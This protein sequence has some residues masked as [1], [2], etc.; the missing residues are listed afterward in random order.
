M[1]SG[2][3]GYSDEEAA[4]LYDVLSPWDA[5]RFASDAFYDD[6][7][8][9]A[10]SVLD[11]GCGTGSMMAQ[12]RQRGHRGRLTGLD[13]DR[14][15]LDR[16]RA[17]CP[18]AEWVQGVAARASWVGEFDL[19]TM[20]SHAF[21]FLVTD[22]ELGASL[23]AIK[24]ALRD[25]GLFAFET[26]HPQA[27]AWLDW[28]PSQVTDV[29]DA[30]GR[31]LRTWHEVESVDGDVVTFTETTAAAGTGTVLRV[32]RARLRFL[33]VPDLN[34]FL[35]EA[36]FVIEAQY[37]DWDRSPVTKDSREIITLARR[38]LAG[39]Q[40]AAE[41][42][43]PVAGVPGLAGHVVR[44]PRGHQPGERG[45]P[46]PRLDRDRVRARPDH[47]GDGPRQRP[48]PSTFQAVPGR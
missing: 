15:A 46:R 38:V 20:T 28:N 3:Q 21:Q 48:P 39:Q 31:A 18:Q 26:R 11:V 24:A 44:H 34:G 9:N 16:A 42:S 32:D 33:D 5:G 36:G 29:R 27:R 10:G 19:A 37:G 43:H 22:D 6:L 14:A 23:D 13:P 25:G 2:T 40:G 45:L 41:R 12:A 30:A 1:G 7:V 17:R 8:M 35:T 4:A 47:R